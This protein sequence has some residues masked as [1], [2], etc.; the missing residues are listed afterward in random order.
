MS[1]LRSDNY[2]LK[3]KLFNREL[4]RLVDIEIRDENRELE[5]IIS[6]LRE[7]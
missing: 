2:N 7:I 6:P 3:Q 4:N 5:T 1:K